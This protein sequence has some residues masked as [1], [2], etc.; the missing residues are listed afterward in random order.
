MITIALFKE[1][2]GYGFVTVEV[3]NVSRCSSET[4]KLRYIHSIRGTPRDIAINE[5]EINNIK[6][7][8][9]SSILTETVPLDMDQFKSKHGA[10]ISEELALSS[11]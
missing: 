4:N 7:V 8:P 10:S 2:S 5:R 3:T 11:V 1:L 6:I 9:F